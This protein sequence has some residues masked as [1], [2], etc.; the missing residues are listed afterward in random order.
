MRATG[1]QPDQTPQWGELCGMSKR[2]ATAEYSR[3]PPALRSLM[4]SDGSAFGLSGGAGVGKTF[5]LAAWFKHRTAEMSRA[6]QLSMHRYADVHWLSWIRWPEFVNTIRAESSREGGLF[7]ASETLNALAKA[8]A[9]VLDDLGAERMKGGYED[10]WA[11]SQLDLLVD[12][13]FNAMLPLWYTTNL[14]P[15]GLMDRYG[16]RFYSRLTGG[17]PLFVVAASPDLRVKR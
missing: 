16:A 2:E 12:R 8:R 6:G 9:V 1:I 15:K 17:S 10:D 14:A 13:R 11:T 3:I 7:G 4:P 5:A